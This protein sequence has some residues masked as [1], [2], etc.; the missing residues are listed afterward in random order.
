MLGN[1]TNT[2]MR[3]EDFKGWVQ[4]PD[5]RG[6]LDIIWSC[7]AV[8]V[9]ALWTVLHLNVPG[10]GDGLRHLFARKIRWGCA[11]VL[12][13]DFL[14]LVAA[15]QWDAAKKSVA[16][17]R[18]LKEV[19]DDNSKWCMEHAFYANSGGT[20]IFARRRIVWLSWAISSYTY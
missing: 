17:M 6:T 14:T 9:T 12:A 13:P 15:S 7:V 8:L 18:E 10:E 20:Y 11:S 4:G 16:K 1:N 5:T 19:A 2:S 3:A